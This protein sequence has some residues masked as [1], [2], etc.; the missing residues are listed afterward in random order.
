MIRFQASAIRALRGIF[1]YR[2]GGSGGLRESA[3]PGPIRIRRGSRNRWRGVRGT[4]IIAGF[5]DLREPAEG[6]GSIPSDR[7]FRRSPLAKVNDVRRGNMI[8]LDGELYVVVDTNHVKPGKGPA[9]VQMKIKNFKQGNV[10]NRRFNSTDNVDTAFI[11]K[12]K[13]E[14]L[15]PEG[16][17][18]IFM[19]SSSYDQFMIS[20]DL[21]EDSMPYITHNSEVTVTIYE[22]NP[23]G[24]EIPASV[25]LQVTETTPGEKGDSVTNVF[26]EA[27]LETGLKTKVPL[28]INQGEHVKVDTNTGEFI[29]RV[30]K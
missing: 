26:K 8:I 28:F 21:I 14:Y 1:P 9:Y 16:T 5:Q 4:Y 19:D 27:T 25:V 6:S 11:T 2:P 23:I 7:F 30:K 15:Y 18:Y 17:G 29:E 22:G 24:V 12:R 3:S 10:T 13:C 20:A